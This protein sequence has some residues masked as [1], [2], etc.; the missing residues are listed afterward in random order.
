[1]TYYS[2]NL[3][4][5][6]EDFINFDFYR[7][8]SVYDEESRGR[9]HD[10]FWWTGLLGFMWLFLLYASVQITMGIVRIRGQVDLRNKSLFLILSGADYKVHQLAPIASARGDQSVVL[11][12]G[13]HLC[14]VRKSCDDDVVVIGFKQ[15]LRQADV[16]TLIAAVRDFRAWKRKLN[17]DADTLSKGRLNYMFVL[18]YLSNVLETQGASIDSVHMSTIRSYVLRAIPSEKIFLYQH[19][20]GWWKSEF[21]SQLGF[22]CTYVVWGKAHITLDNTEKILYG[23]PWHERLIELGAHR[24]ENQTGDVRC[25]FFSDLYTYMRR[26]QD[27][28]VEKYVDTLQQFDAEHGCDIQIKLHMGREKIT[29]IPH[30]W[31]REH[32]ASGSNQAIIPQA[33]VTISD[34][35]SAHVESLV[36]GVPTI[37][38]NE[39]DRVS[40]LTPKSVRELDGVRILDGLDDLSPDVARQHA[41]VGVDVAELREAGIVGEADIV[42]QVWARVDAVR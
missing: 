33:D 31:L 25:L 13:Q 14:K 34:H 19:G 24:A 3:E 37:L 36:A 8:E 39:T 41:D 9:P 42:D 16:S 17:P 20:N 27:D 4:K 32:V 5:I 15:M 26:E 2:A 7:V 1:M 40:E 35:S 10:E 11:T 12:R 23:N 21:L 28:L 22:K 29:D 38:I 18:I 30:A 6:Q